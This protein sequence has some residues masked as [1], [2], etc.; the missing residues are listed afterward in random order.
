[1]LLVDDDQDILEL[2][3]YN[4]E[5][6]GYE[7]KN[8]SEPFFVIDTIQQFQPNVAIMD[9]MM[10]GLNGLELCKQIR[11][12]EIGRDLTIF[13]MT[14]GSES[15]SESAI[16]FGGDDFIQKLSGLR[17][18]INKV[19]LV[20]KRKFIIRKRE[21]QVSFGHWQLIKKDRS[22]ISETRNIKL[23]DLEFDL[24]YFLAQ[25]PGRS[26]PIKYLYNVV[27]VSK[28]NLAR[29]SLI[30]YLKHLQEKFDRGLIEFTGEY[31]VRL[32]SKA[33]H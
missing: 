10:P 33:L 8:I 3:Q 9:I 6:E 1:V 12:L 26:I 23:S 7:V 14:S 13:F 15:L 17:T 32:N 20:L 21:P 27:E 11:S 19:N 29:F 31:R 24:L 5:K 22:V 18:L 2:L 30:R 25:N 4:L 16:K 28:V